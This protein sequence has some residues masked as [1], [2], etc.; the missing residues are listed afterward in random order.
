VARSLWLKTGFQL[1]F[2]PRG[3]AVEIR[4]CPALHFDY[5]SPTPYFTLL[6]L[7]ARETGLD[8]VEELLTE[9]REIPVIREV[10]L[11]CRPGLNLSSLQAESSLKV[12]EASNPE[13]VLA[14][15]LKE[16]LRSL[17]SRSRHVIL[18]LANEAPLRAPQLVELMRHAEGD[19]QHIM[20]PVRAGL[21]GHPLVIPRA[22]VLEMGRF[23]KEPGIP[24]FVRR[25]SREISL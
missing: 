8:G 7:G 6:I 20:V 22:L 23:R 5:P 19:W 15:S 17:S 9:Y 24:R 18:C 10:I 2:D 21:R 3:I 25:Y 16:G 13:D 4:G 12:V 1:S 11:V 14:V